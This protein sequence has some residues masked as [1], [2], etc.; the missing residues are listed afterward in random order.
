MTNK[1]DTPE[2]KEIRDD[3]DKY[4]AIAALGNQDGGKLLLEMLRSTIANCVESITS[5]ADGEDMKLRCAALKLKVNLDLYR[6]LKRA[7]ENVT[8]A[9]EALTKLLEVEE[10]KG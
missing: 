8:L 5:L 7:D 10:K 3:L 4:K 2:I 6:A 9:E 1:P